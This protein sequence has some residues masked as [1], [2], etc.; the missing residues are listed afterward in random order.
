[1]TNV[2]I[3]TTAD[4]F[5]TWAERL[6]SDARRESQPGFAPHKKSPPGG[7]QSK[8]KTPVCETC[9]QQKTAHLG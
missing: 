1:M 3:P 8:R 2:H 5:N 7:P 4:G 9:E 6:S